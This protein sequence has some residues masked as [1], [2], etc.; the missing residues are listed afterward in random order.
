M[1]RTTITRTLIRSLSGASERRRKHRVCD[2]RLRGFHAEC[3]AAGNVT[4][5]LR[6]RDG[7]RAREVRIGRYG[8]ISVDQAR[9]RAEELKASVTTGGDPAG[10]RDR[11]RAMPTLA[12]FVRDRFL[13]YAER[14]I[15]SAGDYEAMC[16]L[17]I[18]PCLGKFRLDQVSP[19]HVADFYRGLLTQGL[20]NARVNRHVATLRRAFNLA[21]EWE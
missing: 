2:D 3:S 11:R 8:E 7:R 16:R 1:T 17:R 6:Y 15:R 10:E 21:I 5:W 18:L 4:F 14:T 20:S 19:L 12:E 9:K 13:P